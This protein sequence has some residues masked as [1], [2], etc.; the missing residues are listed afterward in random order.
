MLQEV[1]IFT[2]LSDTLR[3]RPARRLA[4][5]EC[6]P[7]TEGLRVWFPAG[8]HTWAVGSTPAQARWGAGSCWVFLSH[9]DFS[10][11]FPSL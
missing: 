9:T 2:L 4:R 7:H 10:L 11:P 8:A 1:C 3:S 5:R 6:R